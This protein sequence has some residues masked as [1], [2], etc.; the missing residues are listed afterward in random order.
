MM[1]I[2]VTL[3]KEEGDSSQVKYFNYRKKGHNL[4]RCLQKEKQESKN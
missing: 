2:N 3:K 1:G 4:N